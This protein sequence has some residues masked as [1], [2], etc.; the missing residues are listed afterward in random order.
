MGTY[1]N[2]SSSR[3]FK[4]TFYKLLVFKSL[5]TDLQIFIGDLVII[6]QN[7][8]LQIRYVYPRSSI[9]ILASRIS[10]E[11]APDSGS[12]STTKKEKLGI[13]NP[14]NFRYAL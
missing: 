4:L 6:K 2:F 5:A 10:V 3:I 9:R 13:F 11:L 14:T 7:P 8:V 1:E 12:G